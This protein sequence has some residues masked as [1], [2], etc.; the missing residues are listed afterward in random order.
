MW[1]RRARDRRIRTSF[2][3]SSLRQVDELP[4][5]QKVTF[6]GAIRELDRR[7]D[8]TMLML[9]VDDVGKSNERRITGKDWGG[10]IA[11]APNR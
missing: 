9:E 10:S 5:G 6:V 7:G 3:R 11:P 2:S 1:T 8:G 4:A